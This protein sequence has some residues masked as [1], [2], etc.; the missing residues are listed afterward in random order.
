MQ[1]YLLVK[2]LEQD[3]AE[4]M[5]QLEQTHITEELPGQII[6]MKGLD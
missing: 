3:E 4:D 5:L 2:Q 1:P 6:Y